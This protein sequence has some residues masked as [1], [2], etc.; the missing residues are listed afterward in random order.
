MG[1]CLNEVIH[2][3]THDLLQVIVIISI[4][5]KKCS[6]KYLGQHYAQGYET[7]SVF[8]ITWLP[9]TNL[10]Y[11]FLINIRHIKICFCLYLIPLIYV[12]SQILIIHLMYICTLHALIKTENDL[13]WLRGGPDVTLCAFCM[14]ATFVTSQPKRN[15]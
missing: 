8:N 6:G 2:E 13:K 14:K 1:V 15:V 5:I 7:P 12:I 9:C 10:S 4:L 3:Q 11:R